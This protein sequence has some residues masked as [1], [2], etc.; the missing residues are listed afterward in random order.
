MVVSTGIS[1]VTA[2]LRKLKISSSEEQS[3]HVNSRTRKL[4]N[5]ECTHQ[6][7]KR[8]Q[9]K[10]MDNQEVVR[11]YKKFQRMMP[12]GE[13][14]SR[15]RMRKQKELDHLM[16]QLY[17]LKQEKRQLLNDINFFTQLYLD[18]QHENKILRALVAELTNAVNFLIGIKN[19]EFI[20]P[21]TTHSFDRAPHFEDLNN[22]MLIDG[23]FGDLSTSLSIIDQPTMP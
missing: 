20:S 3:V 1:S 11:E 4:S 23:C 17:R 18:A 8:K 19:E 12:N 15:P 21:T 16:A 14:A 2:A 9:K 22:Q 6:C 5:E 7:R 10:K 13:S